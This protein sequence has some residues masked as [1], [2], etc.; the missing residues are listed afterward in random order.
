MRRL[1]AVLLPLMLVVPSAAS[2]QAEA[3]GL[4]SIARAAAE[5]NGFS[6]VVLVAAG[7]DVLVDR[8][9]GEANREWGIANGVD[10][11]F[12][13]GSLT[14]QF[15]AALVLKL[16]DDGKVDLD[17]PIARYLDDAP[18]G[19]AKVSV[20]DL[21]AHTSGIPNFTTMDGF[22]A[23]AMTAR[24]PNEIVGFF[25]GQPLDFAP[26][27]RFEYSNSNY[28]VLGLL[29]QRVTGR[30]YGALL[31]DR[32]F[33]PLGLGD[34]GLDSD[35]LVLPH[36]AAGYRWRDGALVRARG[37]S[38]SV[39]W[40]A[41][42]VYSTSHDLLDWARALYGGRVLS[43]ESLAAMTR[44]GPGDYGLGQEVGAF[45]GH[46]LIEHEGRIE[47]YSSYLGYLP[48]WKLTVVVLSNV[49]DTP[50]GVLAHRL[51]EG[52]AAR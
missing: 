16:V 38:I 33:A 12:R 42:G 46:R 9:F 45:R 50:A 30:A 28:E 29:L 23:W 25:R 51:I 36:R 4:V 52:Y 3:P 15:T 1:L 39:P 26:G 21:L 32:L 14:K 11:R 34:S 13:L 7:D 31:H 22:D 8:G 41:G 19:W 43:A 37:I 6:G 47:G 35:A 2:A 18:A 40:A 44:K 49:S 20:R 5:Q 27:S 17:A 10:T 24:E 48:D